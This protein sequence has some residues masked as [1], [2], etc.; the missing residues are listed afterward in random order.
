[1]AMMVAH[2]AVDQN[3]DRI[4]ED[5]D[6]GILLERLSASVLVGAFSKVMQATTAAM[7]EVGEK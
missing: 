4:F 1:M 5:D 3:G 2:I 7:V 6:G